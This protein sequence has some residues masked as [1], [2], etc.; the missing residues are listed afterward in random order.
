MANGDTKTNQYLDVAANGTRA[1][2]PTDTCCET[3]TQ[4]LI[5]GVA[6]RIMDLEDE[7]ERLENNPDVVDI[8]A[9]YADLQ[10]YDT[11]G[12]TDKDIIRVLEDETH[13]DNSTYYRWDAA[14]SQFTFVGEIAGG[15]TITELTTDDYNYPANSPDGINPLVLSTGVYKITKGVSAYINKSGVDLVKSEI[16]GDVYFI[17]DNDPQVGSRATII[18][19]AGVD[20]TDSGG[21]E[22]IRG[23]SGNN[24]GTQVRTEHSV[25]TS[26]MV[27]DNLT[28]TDS[29]YPLSANQGRILKDM[30]DNLP[31]GGVTELTA[32]DYN[33]PTDNPTYVGLWLLPDGLYYKP[34][35]VIG[36]PYVGGDD[37]GWELIIVETYEI[38]KEITCIGGDLASTVNGKTKGFQQYE[39]TPTT[40]AFLHIHAPLVDANLKQTT[41]TS[42]TD[43]MSQNAT[44]SMVYRNGDTTKI[45]I[46]SSSASGS[47]SPI[48]IGSGATASGFSNSIAVGARAIAVSSGAIAIGGGNPAID[49]D[50]EARAAGAIALGT[51]AKAT[52]QG[53]MD[54][55]SAN[56]TSTGYNN[57]NYR[58][59]TGLYDPQNDHDAATKG[60]VD[61]STDSSAPT[62]STAG[63]LGQ[64]HIDTTN[65]DAYMCVAADSVT[66]SYTWKKIT[67]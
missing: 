33:Y 52:Q 21:E 13:D 11:S 45:Q 23:I 53:Q 35:N 59:L 7:V 1:D 31:T 41:G 51:G 29:L 37:Y 64:I 14:T 55:G 60:Y 32:A 16:Y 44:T 19:P 8:V 24:L 25:L 40:G 54:I 20:L 12:L 9:T 66:P 26:Q 10:T 67:A 38:S 61:P 27:K 15:D 48:A 47:N 49:T 18:Y 5:R 63:R 3:R 62:T 57:S 39:V 22:W 65:G 2:L 28:S 58:L 50:T 43:V 17:V 46:G 42:T 56:D 30:I 36:R 4:T 6:N 34:S